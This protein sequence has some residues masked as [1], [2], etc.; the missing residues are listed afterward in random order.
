MERFKKIIK[1]VMRYLQSQKTN[2]EVRKF[3]KENKNSEIKYSKNI[4]SNNHYWDFYY[5]RYSHSKKSKYYLPYNYFVY[6]IQPNLNSDKYALYVEDK[7]MYDRVFGSMGV[8]LPRTIFR[9]S[10]YI[11]MDEHYNTIENIDSYIQNIRQ[12][13][14]VKKAIDSYGGV[15]IEKYIYKD[16]ILVNGKSNEILNIQELFK[17]FEGNFVVQ[18]EIIQY[19]ALGKL[20]PHSLNTLRIESYRSVKTNKVHVLMASLRIGNNKSIVDNVSSGG[21]AVGLKIDDSNEA[22]LRKYS[23]K[24][25]SNDQISHHPLSNIEFENYRIPNFPLVVKAIEKLSN[26]IAY[27][28]II[29]WDFSIDESGEPVLIE[30]NKTGGIWASQEVNESPFFGEFSNEVKEYLNNK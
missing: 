26:V 11:Y 7:N 17:K 30:L 20:H 27:Q 5:Q 22:K 29:S 6:K 15:D 16:G 24:P 2:V 28:R 12:N 1:S 25:F 8:R 21:F 10:N 13:I 4:W 14:F 23:F 3:Y 18:E 19:E 9:C